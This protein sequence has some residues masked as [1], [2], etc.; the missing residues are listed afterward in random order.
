MKKSSKILLLVLAV[1]L[2]L[3]AIAAAVHLSARTPDTAGTIRVERAGEAVTVAWDELKLVPVQGQMKTG[4]GETREIDA[5]G[6]LLR[7]LIAAAGFD[8]AGCAGAEV[9]AA[10]SYYA[11]VDAAELMAADKVYIIEQEE[12]GFRQIV[13]G[14]E[15]S[16]RNIS[17]VVSVTVLTD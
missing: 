11:Q 8:P 16:K 7:D 6:I 2:A 5:R 9:T 17:D 15:N 10:D 3:T 4:K 14:D 13:F 1:L 12:G